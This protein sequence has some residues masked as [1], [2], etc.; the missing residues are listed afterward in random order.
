MWQGMCFF[1]SF[2][3]FLLP[4][5]TIVLARNIYHKDMKTSSQ[6]HDVQIQE[7]YVKTRGPQDKKHLQ[8]RDRFQ[9][10]SPNLQNQMHSFVVFRKHTLFKEEV[11]QPLL[12]TPKRPGPTGSPEPLNCYRFHWEQIRTKGLTMS[13]STIWEKRHCLARNLFFSGLRSCSL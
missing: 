1:L 12:D 4:S 10:V 6:F 7:N 13:Q 9:K 11:L 2:R 8:N 5:H 3:P